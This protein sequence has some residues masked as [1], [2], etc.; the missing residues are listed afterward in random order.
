LNKLKVIKIKAFP[1]RELN[2]YRIQ[3]DNSIGNLQGLKILKIENL[4]I[5][6]IPSS[7]RKLKK[8]ETLDITRSDTN[9][10]LI[11]ANPESISRLINL[12]NLVL[13]GYG[14][15]MLPSKIDTLKS[16]ESINYIW[17]KIEKYT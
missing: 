2:G 9:S 5:G 8:L 1:P 13:V 14:M 11:F 3:F 15:D 4:N 10:D 17:F 6:P 7:I 16:I 12:K